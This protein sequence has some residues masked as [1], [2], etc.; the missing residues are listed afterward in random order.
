MIQE[1]KVLVTGVTGLIGSHLAEQLLS[2]G[3]EVVGLGYDR[4]ENVEH[5]HKNKNFEYLKVDIANYENL[6]GIFQKHRPQGVFHTAAF[7]PRENQENPFP[8]FETNTKGTLNILEICRA[9]QVEKL[10]YSSSMSVYGKEIQ[11]LPVLETQE[12]KP[13]DF[14]SLSKFQGEELC[15]LYAEQ[16]SLQITVLRYAGVYGLRRLDGVVYG[17]AHNALNN[18]PLQILSNTSWDIVYVKDV[19]AANILAFRKVENLSFEVF[20]IGNGKEIHIKD[21]AQK[22]AELAGSTSEIVEES[23]ASSFRFFYDISKARRMLGFNPRSLEKGLQ[24]Y[25]AALSKES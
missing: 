19:V 14:Y 21:L 8:F 23:N 7:L 15:K 13:S 22:V 24:E 20:N 11:S 16:F 9:L 17:F 1:Q 2:E 10:I 3:Y 6:L 18:K 12:V 5:L 4:G 25:I